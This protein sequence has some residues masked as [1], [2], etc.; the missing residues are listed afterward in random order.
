MYI[1]IDHQ[2]CPLAFP[3]FICMQVCRDSMDYL[4]EQI[5]AIEPKLD[6]YQKLALPHTSHTQACQQGLLFL[7]D[8]R[9]V[10][11]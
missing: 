2:P 4:V 5:R 6:A 10:P 11:A 7:P 8:C 1:V 9:V 3:G